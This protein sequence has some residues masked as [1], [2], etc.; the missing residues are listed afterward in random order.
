MAKTKSVDERL[1]DSIEKNGILSFT[2][3]EKKFGKK[4]S[5]ML[6]KEYLKKNELRITRLGGEKVLALA[7]KTKTV[8]AI[9]EKELFINVHDIYELNQWD[10]HVVGSVFRQSSREH[11]GIEKNGKVLA[12]IGQK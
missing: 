3:F 8:L 11:Y 1:W 7:N 2:D 6:S 10:A 9:I 4:P 5:E 12:K